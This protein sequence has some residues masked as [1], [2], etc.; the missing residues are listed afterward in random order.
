MYIENIHAFLIYRCMYIWFSNVHAMIKD[1]LR[2]FYLFFTWYISYLPLPWQIIIQLTCLQLRI[3]HFIITM[4][5]ITL[6]KDS[7]LEQRV[8]RQ[9]KLCVPKG[10]VYLMCVSYMICSFPIHSSVTSLFTTNKCQIYTLTYMKLTACIV[11]ML[12]QIKRML[13]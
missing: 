9:K 7:P 12:V 3:P 2:W 10:S 4:Q 6:K 5:S 1:F 13:T 11:N 8:K